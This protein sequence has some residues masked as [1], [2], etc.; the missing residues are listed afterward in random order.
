MIHAEGLTKTFGEP[1]RA[2]TAVDRLTL[3]VA[4]GEVFGFLG[5]NGAGKTTTVRMLTCLIGPTAGRASI[6]GLE[7][8]RDD[9]AIRQRVGLLTETPG[10]YDRLSAEKN[11]SLFARLYSVPD[12]PGQLVQVLSCLAETRCNILDVQHYRS[13]W[14]VP[15]GFVDVEVLIETRHS[16][17][18]AEV[19]DLLRGRGFDVKR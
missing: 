12:V 3:E 19:E 8:G 7:V 2:I 17:Q 5:P 6:G 14:R 13:G 9:Q 16:G 4:Q 1:P 10:M 18:G 15:V 11:L